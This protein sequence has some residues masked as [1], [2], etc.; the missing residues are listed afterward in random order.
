MKRKILC[1]LEVLCII[2]IPI[3]I[4]IQLWIGWKCIYESFRIELILNDSN[5]KVVEKCLTNSEYNN[6]EN[7]DKIQF[8]AASHHDRYVLYYSDGHEIAFN[9]NCYKELRKYIEENG[10]SF[11]Y[12]Y[13]IVFGCLAVILI[14]IITLKTM[15]TRRLNMLDNSEND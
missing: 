2:V 14:I 6:L 4:F 8:I 3:I 11:Y 12:S 10:Q 5:K 13:F 15:V 1:M 7:V 9:G